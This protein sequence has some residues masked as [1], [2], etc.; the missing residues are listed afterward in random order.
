MVGR[1]A[2]VAIGRQ[3]FQGYPKQTELKAKHP[4]MKFKTT[5]LTVLLVLSGINYSEHLARASTYPDAL[6]D[7]KAG[8]ANQGTIALDISSI[9]VSFNSTSFLVEMTFNPST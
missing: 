8:A 3:N 5:A 1:G 4:M 2:L 9:S 6:G 7:A